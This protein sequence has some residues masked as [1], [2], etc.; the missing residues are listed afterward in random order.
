MD[1]NYRTLE[2]V[3]EGGIMPVLFLVDD[4]MVLTESLKRKLEAEVPKVTVVAAMT[5]KEAI[6]AAQQHD[7]AV[8]ITNFSLPDGNAIDLHKA[9]QEQSTNL[10]TIMYSAFWPPDGRKEAE[11]KWA[12]RVVDAPFG[13][14]LLV[15]YVKEALIIQNV[16][17][18]ESKSPK[19][20]FSAPQS[21]P[22]SA[23]SDIDN[24]DAILEGLKK[25][26]IVDD[27]NLHANMCSTIFAPYD[28]CSIEFA[29]SGLEALDM[30]NVN[31][32]FDLIITDINMPHMDGISLIKEMKKRGF[33]HLP[34]IV[35][36][37][38]DKEKDILSA[39]KL[40]ARGYVTKPWRAAH[41]RELI[42]RVLSAPV[43][44]SKA[45]SSAPVATFNDYKE[46]TVNRDSEDV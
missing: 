21:A 27:S 41:F 43:K 35:V 31:D 18:K 46:K 19:T 40:G 45:P 38:E 15:R 13:E 2:S 32:D 10:Q 42:V 8:L 17:A 6:Q 29:R 26:L 23:L 3:A 11:S 20:D 24:T 37:T 1:Y 14:D 33:R 39:L 30:L 7:A 25:V 36:S 9:I 5:S 4:D 22:P 12:F 44:H 28:N 34:V 16:L